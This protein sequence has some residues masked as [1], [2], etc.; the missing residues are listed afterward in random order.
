[1]YVS[2]WK[3]YISRRKEMGR[4]TW[5]K[6]NRERQNERVWGSVRVKKNTKINR[7]RQ[8][9]KEKERERASLYPTSEVSILI[10]TISHC[11]LAAGQIDRDT[12]LSKTP[13]NRKT[14]RHKQAETCCF[15][16]DQWPLSF[17][18]CTGTQHERKRHTKWLSL[19]LPLVCFLFQASSLT[20]FF[21][22]WSLIFPN[23]LHAHVYTWTCIHMMQT[24]IIGWGQASQNTQKYTWRYKSAQSLKHIRPDMNPNEEH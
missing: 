21:F 17:L 18:S 1:M 6:N 20:S 2:M 8:K 10:L 12:W 9:D 4:W 24:L 15:S 7:Q 5:V 3:P 23:L 16:E 14:Q 13:G 22:F 11:S 19:F